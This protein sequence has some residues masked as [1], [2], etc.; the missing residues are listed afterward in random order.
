MTNYIMAGAGL[1]TTAYM[2]FKNKAANAEK[3]ISDSIS[4][5]KSTK[6]YDSL[7]RQFATRYDVD[8]L[9]I[10]S[11][12]YWESSF[13]KNAS[14]IYATY[15]LGQFNNITWQEVWLNYMPNIVING[16]M[17]N[18]SRAKF[19][20][21]QIRDWVPSPFAP[22]FAIEAIAINIAWLKSKLGGNDVL[23]LAAHNAGLPRVLKAYNSCMQQG[24]SG[25]KDRL[26]GFG[27]FGKYPAFGQ[28]DFTEYVD[29]GEFPVEEP[30]PV[31]QELVDAPLYETP[32]EYEN[33]PDYEAQP[34]TENAFIEEQEIT[35]QVS[36]NLIKCILGTLNISETAIYATAIPTIVANAY[37]YQQQTGVALV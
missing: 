30:V 37:A 14:G 32:Q 24:F 21:G 35:I 3:K 4:Y 12:C 16:A 33:T 2:W 18:A 31:Q 8:P 1:L 23:A 7:I 13:N 28:D 10:K 15:G 34:G 11:L 27:R 17:V 29:A 25:F 26:G 19:T 20:L 36:A 6:Q 22:E 9:L 5:F